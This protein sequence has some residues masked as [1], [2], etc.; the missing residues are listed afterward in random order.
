MEILDLRHLGPEHLRALLAEET[1]AW[2][3]QLRWDY[4]STAAMVLRF[5]E[6][7]ALTGYAV[8][9]KGRAV[10]YSFYV[11]ESYKGLIGDAFVSPA[12]RD[13]STEVRLITHVLE[14]LQATPAIRRIEAQLL[15]LD[16]AAIREHFISL[17]FECF[18]R[19]FLF[20]A[21]PQ[22]TLR[23]ASEDFGIH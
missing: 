6:A 8:M 21:L 5:L 10:G 13:G 9:E 7:R 22:A 2:R 14:T 11:L 12:Y 17:G 15:N 3:E 18:D 20:L 4:S 1:T 19:Q 16:T 23:P